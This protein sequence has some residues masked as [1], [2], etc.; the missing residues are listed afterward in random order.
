M[1]QKWAA[2]YIGMMEQLDKEID[3][4]DKFLL[5]DKVNKDK[6]SRLDVAGGS[7]AYIPL[8]PM[9]LTVDAD[10]V[11]WLEKLTEEDKAKEFA[12]EAAGAKLGKQASLIKRSKAGGDC[13]KLPKLCD[14]VKAIEDVAT[15]GFGESKILVLKAG[16]K[17]KQAL[18]DTN[19]N[20]GAIMPL[21]AD[22]SL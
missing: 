22:A 15:N 8:L 16:E 14:A 5:T 6:K 18:C 17:K 21:S 13:D 2:Y 10:R 9:G 4:L 19:G 12:E 11:N 7:V 20:I 3:R 1:G